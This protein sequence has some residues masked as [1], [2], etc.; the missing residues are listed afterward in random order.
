MK[1]KVR[2]VKHK[3]TGIRRTVNTVN[4]HLD[5]NDISPNEEP[6]ISIGNLLG[7]VGEYA[8]HLEDAIEEAEC[9]V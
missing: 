1:A 5:L 3:L 7:Y 9:E 8:K 4:N 6:W 2:D